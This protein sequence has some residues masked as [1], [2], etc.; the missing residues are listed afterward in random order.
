MSQ[1]KNNIIEIDVIENF[2]TKTIASGIE[3]KLSQLQK[4]ENEVDKKQAFDIIFETQFS[5]IQNSILIE[6]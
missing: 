1:F 4:I 2:E 3:F 6:Q 5:N